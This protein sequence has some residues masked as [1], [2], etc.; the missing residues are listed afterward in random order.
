MNRIKLILAFFLFGMILNAQLFN[1]DDFEDDDKRMNYLNGYWFA[2]DDQANNNGNSMS[3]MSFVSPGA[4]GTGTCAY[5]SYTLGADYQHR[6]AGIATNTGSQHPSGKAEMDFTDVTQM[7]V[8]LKGSGH[9]LHIIFQSADAH[10]YNNQTYKMS[11]TP[12]AWSEITINIPDDLE[13]AWSGGKSWNELKEK[14]TAIQF[15]ASSKN[16]GE[17][18]ELRVDSIQLAGIDS[19]VYQTRTATEPTAFGE[20]FFED[21]D[22][23]PIGTYTWSQVCQAW[24]D[25]LFGNGVDEGRVHIIGNDTCFSGNCLR[26]TYP[27]GGTASHE[28]GAQWN[29][30]FP[31]GGAYDS[32]YFEYKV[33]FPV[34][35]DF[36]MGGKLPGFAGG[37][38]P[39]GG[40]ECDGTEGF[41]ARLMWR[42]NSS[43]AD[44]E[45]G[46]I[47]NYVYFMDK[48]SEYGDNFWWGTPPDDGVGS[49]E[50]WTKDDKVWFTPGKWHSV[51]NLVVINTPGVADGK[52]HAWL[53]GVKV[54]E[55]NSLRFRAEQVNSFKVDQFYFSTFFGGSDPIWAP[56][57]TEYVFFDEFTVSTEDIPVD[58]PLGIEKFDPGREVVVSPNPCIGRFNILNAPITDELIDISIYSISGKKMLHLE[59]VNTNDQMAINCKNLDAG[60]Y[61]VSLK[62]PYG[63]INKKLIIKKRQR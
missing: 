13:S 7:K 24:N 17:S 25:P 11:A 31:D 52:I 30:Y 38:A 53:D 35:F 6:F 12:T 56:A 43:G 18:G 40:A 55:N 21:F 22:S 45:H 61:I 57:S 15:K 59:N 19:V 10:D 48:I 62:S 16:V 29:L 26:I 33:Y 42:R 14:I 49:F 32:L 27:E 44:S 60:V 46:Y 8:W 28:S 63:V 39:T 41:S 51:K 20:I 50:N 34:G 2:Y 58:L 9:E 23:E 5:M 37:T 47:S 36:V 4:D 1:L 3:E 54:L